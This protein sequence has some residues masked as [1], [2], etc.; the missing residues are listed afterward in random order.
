MPHRPRELELDELWTFVGREQRKK[1]LWLAVE[2]YTR[3]II[4]WVLSSQGRATARRLWQALPA[5]YRTGTCY[6]TDEWGAYKGVLPRHA[7]RAHPKG[8]G[9][10]S[11]VDVINCSL[12]QKCAVLVRK[13]CSFSRCLAMHHVRIQLVIDE[14]NR[15]CTTA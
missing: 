13:S 15:R 6:H 3:R 9:Q 1:W 2:L 12:R 10:T 8:S 14:H 4:A 5:P 11:I 7:H